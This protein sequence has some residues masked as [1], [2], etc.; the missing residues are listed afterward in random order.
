MLLERYSENLHSSRREISIKP[1][2]LLHSLIPLLRARYQ[3]RPSRSTSLVIKLYFS[4]LLV[5]GELHVCRLKKRRDWLEIDIT[6]ATLEES[7]LAERNEWLRHT[8]WGF[9][10]WK[11]RLRTAR[12]GLEW[13]WSLAAEFCLLR[14]E[15]RAR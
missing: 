10:V 13:S 1:S 6:R 15:V 7:R 9:T 2:L 4:Q 14:A 3:F 12:A 8:I 5:G 11:L